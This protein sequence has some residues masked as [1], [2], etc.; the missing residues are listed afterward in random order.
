M[1]PKFLN[2][3]HAVRALILLLLLTVAHASFADVTVEQI[4]KS[5]D[6]ATYQMIEWQIDFDAAYENPFDPDQVKVD[7]Q[8]QTPSL[9]WG[10]RLGPCSVPKNL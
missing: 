1:Y 2:Q 8:I 7:A 4:S 9:W 5:K 3:N 10:G 6:I